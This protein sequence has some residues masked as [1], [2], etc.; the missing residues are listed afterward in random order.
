MLLVVTARGISSLLHPLTLDEGVS[1][2]FTSGTWSE[3]FAMV[4]ADNH[5]PLF[6]VVLKLWCSVF[7]DSLFSMRALTFL[8]SLLVV[9]GTVWLLSVSLVPP[10]IG[11]NRRISILTVALLFVGLSSVQSRWSHEVRMYCM[12]AALIGVAIP[13]AVLL[14]R[15]QSWTAVFLYSMCGAAMMYTHIYLWFSVAAFSLCLTG[16]M[17]TYSSP[18]GVNAAEFGR[19][20]LAAAA[21]IPFMA[22][23][24]YLPV[25]VRQVSRVQGEF[26]IP[27]I[28]LGG[29]MDGVGGAVFNPEWVSERLRLP[30]NLLGFIVVAWVVLWALTRRDL[31]TWVLALNITLPLA[32]A[33]GASLVGQNIFHWRY[34]AFW[35]VALLGGAAMMFLDLGTASK[36]ALLGLCVF[37]SCAIDVASVADR[38]SRQCGAKSASE[39]VALDFSRLASEDELMVVGCPETFPRLAYYMRHR[40]SGHCVLWTPNGAPH[41]YGTGA[42]VG[43]EFSGNDSLETIASRRDGLWL[44]SYQS[45]GGTRVVPVPAG[46]RVAWKEW[47][48]GCDTR[49]GVL[50]MVHCVPAQGK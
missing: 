14:C 18:A 45:Q 30:A 26:W 31:C 12:G 35:N 40:P 21:V 29:V 15:R 5:P 25:L 16:R 9:A 17:F 42:Y 36:T 38:L 6:F 10:G 32:C 43:R 41:Y 11:R 37:P 27:R 48:I 47:Y 50:E 28:S 24:P 23:T 46:W 2:M 8:L 49:G 22:W 4:P 44:V 34:L 39:S 7:G 3:L 13:L 19:T 33:I 1:W 20:K